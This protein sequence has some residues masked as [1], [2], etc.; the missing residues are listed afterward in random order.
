MLCPLQESQSLPSCQAQSNLPRLGF[1]SVKKFSVEKTPQTLPSRFYFCASFFTEEK[2]A[3]EHKLCVPSVITC[4]LRFEYFVFRLRLFLSCVSSQSC[5]GFGGAGSMGSFKSPQV[6]CG[7]GAG[8]CPGLA[9][10]VE[11]YTMAQTS[12]LG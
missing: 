3:R 8:C 7:I 4:I 11:V 10:C 6:R 9:Q 5:W 12:W 1:E 2:T